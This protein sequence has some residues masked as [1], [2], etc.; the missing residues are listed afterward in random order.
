[1]IPA[2]YETTLQDKFSRDADTNEM[3]EIIR[4]SI[5]LTLD[6]YLSYCFSPTP[7]TAFASITESNLAP[8]SF[9]AANESAWQTQL[10]AVIEAYR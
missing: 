8:A 4:R 9:I 1:M 6:G 2:Y 7:I 3:L 10:E 5:H